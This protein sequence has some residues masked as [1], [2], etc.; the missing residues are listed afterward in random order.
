LK[1]IIKKGELKPYKTVSA[2]AVEDTTIL[3]LPGKAFVDV[4]N[5]YPE[6]LVRITQ[7]IILRLQRV[8]FAALHNHLGLTSEIIETFTDI[9]KHKKKFKT[10]K[11]GDL[12]EN[13]PR[14]RSSNSFTNSE[15]TTPK[16]HTDQVE[17]NSQ[18]T[19][20]HH[21][22]HHHHHH[23][24]HHHHHYNHHHQNAKA[25]SHDQ[26][27]SPS[28]KTEEDSESEIYVHDSISKPRKYSIPLPPVGFFK[29]D[30]ETDVNILV[31]RFNINFFSFLNV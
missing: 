12:N 16:K 26:L 2:K 29:E 11:S 9:K 18:D 30:T 7:I 20:T 4:L 15:H 27:L 25:Q 22:S 31:I 14:K 8:T 5:K 28:K 23:N 21:K 1:L 3:R 19:S 17:Q 13:S 24:H 10:Y 6:Y